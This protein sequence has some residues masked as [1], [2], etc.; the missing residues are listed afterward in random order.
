MAQL[1]KC[2]TA[3]QKKIEQWLAN[4]GVT[5][6]DVADVRLSGP[7]LVRVTNPAGQYMD[8]YCDT[9]ND[10]RVLDISQEREE[11]LIWRWCEETEEP[12]TQEWRG[13]L[14]ADE[15]AMMEQWEKQWAIDL[16]NLLARHQLIAE[17]EPD[18]EPEL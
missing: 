6:G 2:Q 16:R 1:F 14:T 3:K 8:L 17:P 5:A 11:E 9:S 7:A 10:V 18:W 12:E 4:Q 15:D 13:E